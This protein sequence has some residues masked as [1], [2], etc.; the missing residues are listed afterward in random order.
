MTDNFNVG[1][2]VESPYGEPATEEEMQAA[3]ANA[4]SQAPS[5]P[6]A[7]KAPK[8]PKVPKEPKGPVDPGI[9]LCGCGGPKRSVK[10]RF[11][12]GHDAKAKSQLMKVDRGQAVITD[13]YPPLVEYV[14]SNP[15][16]A[17]LFPNVFAP[18]EVPTT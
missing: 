4:G 16:W 8:V 9:C 12:P 15:Q 2:A 11:I 14:K 13:V 5:E 3:L 17:A 6:K 1:G 18:V 7:A 10:A